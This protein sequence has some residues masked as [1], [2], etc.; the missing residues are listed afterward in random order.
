MKL[1][2]NLSWKSRLLHSKEKR[3]SVL[4]VSKPGNHMRPYWP[5][6]FRKN[7]EETNKKIICYH[8]HKPGHIKPNCPKLKKYD[9]KVSIARSYQEKEHNG[10]GAVSLAKLV[11]TPQPFLKGN[12]PITGPVTSLSQDIST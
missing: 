2:S 8:F 11:E 6:H 12:A 10:F 4:Q 7:I 3:D 1:L 9:K 5:P